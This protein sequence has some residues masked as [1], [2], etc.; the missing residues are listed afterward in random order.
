MES[1]KHAGTMDRAKSM[2]NAA[3]DCPFAGIIKPAAAVPV[4]HCPTDPHLLEYVLE[5][6]A[7]VE[8]SGGTTVIPAGYLCCIP[9]GA[10]LISYGDPETPCRKI[11]VQLTG[12]LSDKLLVFFEINGILVTPCGVPELFWE[13]MDCAKGAAATRTSETHGRILEL[14]FLLLSDA[15]KERF[16]P[17]RTTSPSLAERIR[18]YMEGNLYTNL[19]LDRI[20]LHFGFTKMH[21]IRVFKQA[22]GQTPMQYL[23]SRKISIAKSLLKDTIMPVGEI[24][25]LLRYSNTQHFS[26]AFKKAVGQTPHT[27]RRS[28]DQ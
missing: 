22:Y 20:A 14:V 28:G 15:T 23:L 16:F 27:Y 13:I 2:K 9:A 24:A 6:N 10:E 19:S 7:F 18:N 12:T 3:F 8:V 21:V 26:A 11:S 4:A 5:G 17:S 25:S 1:N